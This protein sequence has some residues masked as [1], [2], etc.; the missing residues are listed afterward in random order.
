MS[1]IKQDKLLTY[2]QET[3]SFYSLKE[4]E[5]SNVS[6]ALGINSMEMKNVVK[7]L[8]DENLV[9]TEKIGTSNYYWSFL[10]DLKLQNQKLVKDLTVK[11]DNLDNQIKELNN[12][13][14]LERTN[15]KNVNIYP[16]QPM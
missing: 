3:Q 12:R 10:K 6:K 4:L 14:G 15:R 7:L 9:K 1:K 13:I 8:V 2:F 5:S 16:C 11:V